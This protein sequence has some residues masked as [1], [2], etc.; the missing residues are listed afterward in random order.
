VVVVGLVVVV[1]GRV[2]VVGWEVVVLEA[3]VVTDWAP[4]LQASNARRTTKSE[5]RHIQRS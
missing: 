1:V 5:S 4:L 2:V 3:R